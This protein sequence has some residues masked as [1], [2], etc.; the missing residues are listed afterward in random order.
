MAEGK[1]HST[2]ERE[3]RSRQRGDE[4]VPEEGQ[5]QRQRQREAEV[6]REE[7]GGQVHCVRHPETNAMWSIPHLKDLL[8]NRGVINKNLDRA[9]KINSRRENSL[10]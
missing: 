2:C 1:D 8:S 6:E 4:D 3:I 9:M 7:A 5:R 10:L